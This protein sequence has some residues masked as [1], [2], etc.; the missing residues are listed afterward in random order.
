MGHTSC[1]CSRANSLNFRVLMEPEANKFPKGLMLDRD[2]NI[3]IRFTGSTPLGDVGCYNPPPSGARRP[4]RHTSS[5][6]CDNLVSESI[7]GWKCAN[8]GVRPLRRNETVW[9]LTGLR[10]H[11]N[12]KVKRLCVRAIL[13]WVTHWK[14]CSHEFPETKP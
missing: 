13:G 4:R 11:R 7:P 14:F 2:G 9:E 3:H 6:G 8:E 1:D 10:F 12:S 5:H